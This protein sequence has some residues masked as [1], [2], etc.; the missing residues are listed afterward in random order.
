MHATL[1]NSNIIS[2]DKKEVTRQERDSTENLFQP[3][4]TVGMSSANPMSS[5]QLSQDTLTTSD[6]ILPS[7]EVKMEKFMLWMLTAHIWVLTLLSEE[8]SSMVAA[9]NAPSMAGL[10]MEQQEIVCSALI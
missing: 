8:K 9:F 2:S 10:S 4:L 7:L 5:R 6:S 1:L 3:F